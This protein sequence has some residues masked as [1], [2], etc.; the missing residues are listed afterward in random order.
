MVKRRLAALLVLLLTL[1]GIG[2][3]ELAWRQDTPAQEVLRKYITEV[4]V[5]LA[6]QGEQ[7]INSLFEIYKTQAVLGIT[8]FPDAET[9]ENV[10]ITVT[11]TYDSLNMLQLRVSD[12]AR[13]PVIAAAFLRALEPEAM[14]MEAALAVPAAKAKRAVSEPANSFEEEIE[15]LNGDSPR[16]YYAYFP[17]QYGNGIPWMQMTIVFPLAGLW[18]GETVLEGALPTKGPDTYSGNDANYEGYF[19]EDD[20]T[21]LEVFATETPEPDS[22]AAEFDPYH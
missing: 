19:S 10:E 13:F 16:T 12:I 7:P 3:A 9:P 8:L 15:Q 22:A 2:T 21:H 18:D 14:S 17:N 1:P 4:N 20:Y 6:E 5:F 11:M